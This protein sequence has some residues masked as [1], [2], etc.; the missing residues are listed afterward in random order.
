MTDCCGDENEESSVDDVSVDDPSVDDASDDDASVD[1]AS[2]GDESLPEGDDPG[3][4][5]PE[6][7]LHYPTLEFD[8]GAVEPDGTFE[9]STETSRDEMGAV[10]TDLAGALSSHDLGVETPDGFTTLGIAPKG[11]DV[12]FD[13]DEDHRG[14]LEV[15]FRLSAKAM[16]VAD[17]GAEQVGSRG[18]QGFVP[19]KMLTEDRDLYR[20]Y[21]WV[22]DPS[23]PD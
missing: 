8:D 2:V 9:L 4:A 13:P 6:A 19:L 11:V 15:T 16:F 21:S 14:E 17:D 5:L 3:H 18:G 22:D 20:C 7:D 1:D 23:N 10:A 12:S